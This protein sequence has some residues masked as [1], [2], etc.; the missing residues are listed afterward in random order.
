MHVVKCFNIRSQKALSVC[1][2]VQSL[3][4]IYFIFFFQ[5]LKSQTFE[6]ELELWQK[7]LD[8]KLLISPG[9]AFYCY[10]PGWFRLVFSDSVNKI[11]L[12][13]LVFLLIHR[14][15]ACKP[16]ET[17][18]LFKS[19]Y[20]LSACEGIISPCMK[21]RNTRILSTTLGLCQTFPV[22]GIAS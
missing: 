15:V 14:V 8:K 6:A 3:I 20:P 22:C 13:K 2:F 16:W 18:A 17:L 10:E 19:A 4:I 9:K 21:L 11:Y 5:F 7:L 1:V 12:C